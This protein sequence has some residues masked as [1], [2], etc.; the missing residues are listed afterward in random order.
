MK[1]DPRKKTFLL[2][3]LCMWEQNK[4]KGQFKPHA[5]CV[6]DVESGKSYLI[7]S[8]SHI[9]FEAGNISKPLDQEDYNQKH[10]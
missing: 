1:D 7:K 10:S 9:K 4:Q 5:I 8:G 3:D 6:I 2:T